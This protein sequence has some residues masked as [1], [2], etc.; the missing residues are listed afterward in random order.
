MFSPSASGF[1]GAPASHLFGFSSPLSAQHASWASAT[2]A[3]PSACVQG[4][5]AGGSVSSSHSLASPSKRKLNDVVDISPKMARIDLN[6]RADRQASA[7]AVQARL[8]DAV[9]VETRSNNPLAI[10]PSQAH[11][12]DPVAGSVE[13]FVMEV[14][15]S[16]SLQVSPAALDYGSRAVMDMVCAA[17]RSR[18][19]TGL[20][21]VPYKASNA[22]VMESLTAYQLKEQHRQWQQ[23]QRS[24]LMIDHHDQQ[25]QQQQ[26]QQHQQQQHQQQQQQ[27]ENDIFHHFPPHCLES[28]HS[29]HP[30]LKRRRLAVGESDFGGMDSD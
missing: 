10:S 12:S 18:N 26:H 1:T 13:S 2:L 19:Q 28:D 30:M 3:M 14:M 17:Q 16:A 22:A 27:H 21:L 6:T 8:P 7:I 20:A 15:R 23:R 24:T 11:Q 4:L 5:A 29:Q 9:K 25:Q